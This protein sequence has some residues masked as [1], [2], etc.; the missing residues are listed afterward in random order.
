MDPRCA[1]RGAVVVSQSAAVLPAPPI[2]QSAQPAQQPDK[3]A[4][5][6]QRAEAERW[7]ASLPIKTVLRRALG[8]GDSS[9]LVMYR[10]AA[11]TPEFWEK[12]WLTSPPYRMRGYTLPAWYRDTFIK[13][14]PRDGL[15]V[16]AGC[17]NGNLLRMLVNEDPARWGNVSLSPGQGAGIEGLDFAENAIAENRRIH[18]EGRYRIG[19]VRDLPYQTGELSAYISMGVVEHFEEAER[20]AIL[21]EAARCLRPGGVAIITVPYFSPARRFRARIG[22]FPDESVI[23]GLNSDRSSNDQPKLD[24]YQYFFTRRDIT[25]Q[26]ESSGL[27]VVATDG[28]DCRRGW[29]E[30]FGGSRLLARIE[31]LGSKWARRIEHPPRP[32]RLFCPHMLMVVAVRS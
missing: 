19:D 28:Y 25:R 6:R 12:T 16:E 5:D 8:A 24:F 32:F 21:R 15:M 2:A 9:R 14:L 22:T 29:T 26:I 13:W 18:P 11:A 1:E 30:A 23:A 10:T 7:L 17:G 20:A 4:R 27:T 3:A 31:R